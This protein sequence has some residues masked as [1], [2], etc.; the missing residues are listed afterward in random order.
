MI[1]G[2]TFALL[3]VFISFIFAGE[4]AAA[5]DIN[6]AALYDIYNKVFAISEDPS[7]KIVLRRLSAPMGVRFFSREQKLDQDAQ[8]RAR[9]IFMKNVAS[10][11]DSTGLRFTELGDPASTGSIIYALVSHERD[12]PSLVNLVL[13]RETQWHRDM[14]SADLVSRFRVPNTPCI[15]HETVQPDGVVSASLFIIDFSRDS[16]LR[17]VLL[18]FFFLSG[19][20]LIDDQAATPSIITGSVGARLSEIDLKLLRLHYDKRLQSGLNALEF[21][22]RLRSSIDRP[23]GAKP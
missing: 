4:R 15:S 12:I 19:G 8:L 10:I 7:S 5:A 22:E 13:H 9:T 11:Q 18:S 6:Q 17:C 20:R 1:G 14:V 16:N 23:V 3:V 21:R 2:K